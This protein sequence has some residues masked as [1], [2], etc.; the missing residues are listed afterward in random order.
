MSAHAV[1]YQSRDGC[2]AGTEQINLWLPL[3]PVSQTSLSG[4]SS[5]ER[6]SSKT[7]INAGWSYTRNHVLRL[8]VWHLHVG[9]A[10]GAANLLVQV[11]QDVVQGLSHLWVVERHAC[12]HQLKSL[13]SLDKIKK[14]WLQNRGVP[15]YDLCFFICER[16]VEENLLDS[17]GVSWWHDNARRRHGRFPIFLLQ[18]VRNHQEGSQANIHSLAEW[19]HGADKPHRKL[20]QGTRHRRTGKRK[21]YRLI[22]LPLDWWQR[23]CETCPHT[24]GHRWSPS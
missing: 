6:D 9:H 23:F 16:G 22:E 13:D 21:L 4:G 5:L 15:T 19:T 11:S 14:Q 7:R 3:S 8:F 17:Q 10:H 18:A 12:K 2:H 20:S 1:W 24:G